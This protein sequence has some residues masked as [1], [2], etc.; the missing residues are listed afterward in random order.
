MSRRERICSKVY[1]QQPAK[2][3]GSLKVL[4]KWWLIF[5]RLLYSNLFGQFQSSCW[6]KTGNQ[7]IRFRN[8]RSNR[9]TSFARA[10]YQFPSRWRLHTDN[11]NPS[12]NS[13]PDFS[14]PRPI[15]DISVA[16]TFDR[17]S[18]DFK[19]LIS[20]EFSWFNDSSFSILNDFSSLF[21]SLL[22][23]T[24]VSWK[25]NEQCSLQTA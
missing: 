10:L 8:V 17:V 3:I 19:V 18:D 11:C 2:L 22:L 20:V 13:V 15:F 16:T 21:D 7:Y 6:L 23:M 1:Y 14:F 5:T 25:T 4:Q 9:L 24:L 12:D